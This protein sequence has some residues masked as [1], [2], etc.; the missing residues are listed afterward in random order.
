MELKKVTLEVMK[1]LL[2][3]LCLCNEEK[4]HEARKKRIDNVMLSVSSSVPFKW[5]G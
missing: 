2:H 1:T 4:L 3:A 5:K